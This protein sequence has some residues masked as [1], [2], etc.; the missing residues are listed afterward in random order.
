ALL[1]AVVV[2]QVDLLRPRAV[3]VEGERG[4]RDAAAAGEVEDHLVGERVRHASRQLE[5]AAVALAEDRLAALQVED[6]AFER[7]TAALL[8]DLAEQQHLVAE[9][10]VLLEVVRGIAV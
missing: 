5:A 1:E 8:V 4:E 6:P 2:H 10:A 3:G 7:E 9:R